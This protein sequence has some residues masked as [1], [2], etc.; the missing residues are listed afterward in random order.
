MNNRDYKQF[1]PGNYYHIYNR[2]NGRMD[3]YKDDQD[4][5]NFLKRLKLSLGIEDKATQRQTLQ[6]LPLSGIRIEPLP[7]DAFSIICYCLMPNH[8]HF[9]IKQN[10][11]VSISKLINK[12]CSS[13]T[14]YFN[15]KYD[16]VG[17]LLQDR[18]KAVVVDNDEYLLWLSA[19][20]H[21]NPK[22]AGLVRDLKDYKW[23]SYLYYLNSNNSNS[24]FFCDKDIVLEGF[25]NINEYKDFVE[26]SYGAIKEGKI[27]DKSD[28]ILD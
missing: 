27:I 20:I 22:V 9:L 4:Y 10:N 26:D 11:K 3:I 13:Y 7:K 21:Q 14:K 15:K 24:Q 25:K 12:V 1:A 2:G 5:F 6:S 18:F 19:Y 23:S 16:L 28:I 17:H 8:F